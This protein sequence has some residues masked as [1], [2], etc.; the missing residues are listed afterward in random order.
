MTDELGE[1][2]LEVSIRNLKHGKMSER[3][4]RKRIQR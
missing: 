1:E 4:T 2:W 3:T